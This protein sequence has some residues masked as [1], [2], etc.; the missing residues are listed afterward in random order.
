MEYPIMLYGQAVGR[1]TV[2]REGLYYRFCC[3]CRFDGEILCT[4]VAR[5]GEREEK[6]GVPVPE[7]G[8]FRLETRIP[9]KRLGEG[10]WLFAAVPRREQ[11]RGTFV[12]LSPEEPFR[13]LKRIG[14]AVLQTR[15]GVTGVVIGDTSQPIS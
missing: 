7:G 14:E 9:V 11:A 2:A 10:D 5:R 13:Y 15:D 6:L 1:A 12:P 4:I 3:R 8:E